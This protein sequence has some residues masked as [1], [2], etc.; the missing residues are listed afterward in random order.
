M[1]NIRKVNPTVKIDIYLRQEYG[2]AMLRSSKLKKNKETK[3]QGDQLFRYAYR[4]QQ[5]AKSAKLVAKE[6][7]E[8]SLIDFYTDEMATVVN[9]IHSFYAEA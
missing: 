5:I 9:N 4:L 2:E 8:Q 1:N 7:G 3:K 6:G